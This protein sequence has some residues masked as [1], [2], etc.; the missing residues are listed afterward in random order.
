L[1]DEGF[2]EW[3]G[4]LVIHCLEEAFRRKPD[5]AMFSMSTVSDLA[6]DG[7]IEGIDLIL[8]TSL[9][10]GFE[11]PARIQLLYHARSRSAGESIHKLCENRSWNRSEHYKK[12]INASLALAEWLNARGMSAPVRA[13]K[14]H[15]PA[16][17]GP[18]RPPTMGSKP[19][20]QYVR[21]RRDR[22]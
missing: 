2:T 5:A 14:S 17:R 21:H 22:T 15:P 19:L 13:E 20:K 7:P 4:E 11:S 18:G 12:V 3:T 9:A 1:I 6:S 8:A 16:K 10:L